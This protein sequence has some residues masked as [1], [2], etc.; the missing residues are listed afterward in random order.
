MSGSQAA[1][2]G[3]IWPFAPNLIPT[4]KR[5]TLRANR[6]IVAVKALA[7]PC[8]LEDTASGNTING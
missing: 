8:F 1:S 4:A 3:D 6:K 5:K 2:H 7:F